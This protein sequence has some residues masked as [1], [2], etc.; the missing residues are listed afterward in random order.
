MKPSDFD[1]ISDQL[2][3]NELR[4]L[5]DLWDNYNFLYVEGPERAAKL[6]R[7]RWGGFFW[8]L[9]QGWMISAI[10]LSISRLTDSS[11]MGGHRNQTLSALLDDPRLPERLRRELGFEMESVL[12]LAEEIRK[13]RNRVVAHRDAPTA[14]GEAARPVLRLDEIGEIIPRLQD[15]HRKHRATCMGKS[16]SE[17][18][19]HTL[20]GVEHLVKCLEQSE[21]ARLLFA[22]SNRSDEDKLRD[23]DAAERVFFPMRADGSPRRLQVTSPPPATPPS[24][25]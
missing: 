12:E 18:G 24:D 13:H 9:V 11:K 2:W 15:I 5:Q 7:P 8:D 17:Y 20:R 10:V 1:E 4:E 19:T 3:D 23:W 25:G 22:Q 14:V 6:R 16:V 21:Q